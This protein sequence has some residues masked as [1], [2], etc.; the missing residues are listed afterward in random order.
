MYFWYSFN[1]VAPIARILPL[2]R[3]GLSMFDASSVPP[4][5]VPVP[6]RVCNSSMNK[7]I[8][9]PEFS[10][11]L[12]TAFNR[13]SNSPRYFVPATKAPMSSMKID[14]F[15]NN[16]GTSPEAI[17]CARPSA[18]AVFPTPASPIKT[19]LFLLRRQS[20]CIK[21]RIS[22]SL[23]MIGSSSPRRAASVRSDPYFSSV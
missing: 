9:P 20:T 11:S 8:C 23:P 3:A 19:G 2:A 5:V 6:T 1:V 7:I 16:S 17:R 13:S 21:R 15:F 14:L 18:I 10:I 22:E 4:S 12:I